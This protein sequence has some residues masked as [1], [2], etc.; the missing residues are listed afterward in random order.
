ML[1]SVVVLNHDSESVIFVYRLSKQE[2][3]RCE[4]CFATFNRI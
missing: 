4:N 1:H 3:M 2:G